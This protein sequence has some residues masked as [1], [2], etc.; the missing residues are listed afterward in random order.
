M[1]AVQGGRD[2]KV[3]TR[4]KTFKFGEKQLPEFKVGAGE[5][6]WIVTE[7]NW[8]DPEVAKDFSITIYGTEGEVG[9]WHS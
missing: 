6:Y 2:Q 3:S 9:L 7:W 4:V 1:I 5:W 8:T